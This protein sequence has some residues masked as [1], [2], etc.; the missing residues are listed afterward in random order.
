[1]GK[2][3]FVICAF[4]RHVCKQSPGKGPT[5]SLRYDAFELLM[6]LAWSPPVPLAA[7]PHHHP[8]LKCSVSLPRYAK[9]HR[10]RDHCMWPPGSGPCLQQINLAA[11]YLH[12]SSRGPA[13]AGRGVVLGSDQHLPVACSPVRF[14][15]KESM[16]H[17]GSIEGETGSHRL[18]AFGISNI[19][20]SIPYLVILS[21][22]LP[23]KNIARFCVK[24]I[25]GF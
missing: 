19:Q 11:G 5:A 7:I 12:C 20:S 4:I 2:K 10:A 3:R 14:D 1:M 17:L 16:M 8:F 15:Q 23:I 13:T 21:I 9:T 25:F 18:L 22:C 6:S 24:S